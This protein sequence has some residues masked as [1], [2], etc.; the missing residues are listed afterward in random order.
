[1]TA[2]PSSP[3]APSL[4]EDDAE[5]V[6]L[7]RS[8]SDAELAEW[9]SGEGRDAI[10]EEIFGQMEGRLRPD[11]ARGVRGAIQWRVKGRPDGGEDVFEVLVDDGSC[12]VTRGETEEPR[13]TMSVDPVSFLK[14]MAQATGSTKLVLRRKLRIKGDVG[15]AM[16]SEHLFRKPLD[17]D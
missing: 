5:F 8:T 3:G 2:T 4:P 12:R 9:M 10:L 16:R 1:M 17:T 15:F 14:L 7:V 6:E 11:R 13:A